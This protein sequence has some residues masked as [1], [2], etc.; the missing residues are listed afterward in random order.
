MDLSELTRWLILGLATDGD[1]RSSWA[2]QPGMSFESLTL[3]VK[4]AERFSRGDSKR[5]IDF[6]ETR[7][8]LYVRDKNISADGNLYFI[9]LLKEYEGKVVTTFKTNPLVIRPSHACAIRLMQHLG[10][11]RYRIVVVPAFVDNDLV[12][13]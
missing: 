2:C 4:A 1:V 6:L 7:L 5:M 13:R 8:P 12:V 10:A 11:K 3:L 9:E